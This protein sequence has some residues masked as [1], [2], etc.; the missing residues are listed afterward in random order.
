[1]KLKKKSNILLI[2]HLPNKKKKKK[3]KFNKKK[4]RKK[5][6]LT[7]ENKHLYE[8]IEHFWTRCYTGEV[9]RTHTPFGPP[10]KNIG[11]GIALDEKRGKEI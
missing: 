6:L 11:F 3:K 9:K 5:K 4:K 2:T 7:R 10:L 1:V 8:L